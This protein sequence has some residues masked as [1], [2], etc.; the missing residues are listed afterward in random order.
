[1][2]SNMH[3]F[4]T[5]VR[6]TRPPQQVKGWLKKVNKSPV[7][8]DPPFFGSGPLY[9]PGRSGALKQT[10]TF[11]AT[12]LFTPARSWLR[13]TYIHTCYS[14]FKCSFFLLDAGT[15]PFFATTGFGALA[16]ADPRGGS[17][18]ANSAFWGL[19]RRAED[20]CEWIISPGQSP[21]SDRLSPH[22]KP[23]NLCMQT[24]MQSRA[25]ITRCANRHTACRIVSLQKEKGERKREKRKRSPMCES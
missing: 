23:T 24:C 9:D 14:L 21:P 13:S 5:S 7:N 18:S 15:R 6:T 20:V 17:S 12:L 16:A 1:M 3:R 4:I 25:R 10:P 2:A 22:R 8:S 11:P 19:K